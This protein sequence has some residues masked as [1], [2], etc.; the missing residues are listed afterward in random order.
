MELLQNYCKKFCKI[1]QEIALTLTNS[2]KILARVV[3]VLQNFCKICVFF[4]KFLQELYSSWTNLFHNVFVIALK[5]SVF[6]YQYV[7]GT[8]QSIQNQPFRVGSDNDKNDL[9]Q[10]DEIK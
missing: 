2:C 5:V 10:K 6:L 3:L 1:L 4:A 9:I 8:L 7:N